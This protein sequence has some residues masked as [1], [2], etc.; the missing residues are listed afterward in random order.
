MLYDEN[1]I[2]IARSAIEPGCRLANRSNRILGV[3]HRFL[4]K[5]HFKDRVYLELGPG[6]FEFCDMVK[7]LGGRAVALEFDPAMVK[8]G[9][10][11]GHEVRQ[12]NLIKDKFW[13]H[14]DRKFDGIFCRG[15]INAAWFT[16]LHE[17]QEFAKGIAS[18]IKPDGWC[19]ISPWNSNSMN[20]SK[21]EEEAAY[22]FQLSSFRA[23]GFRIINCNRFQAGRFKLRTVKRPFFIFTKG[24]TYQHYFW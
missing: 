10:Y 11:R 2:Q 8:L 5:Q 23:E 13:N 4:S 14:M 16:E 6:H 22:E 12:T 17:H 9:Q 21:D 1:E 3:Y 20:L 18:L 24:L 19:W 7:K 15:S